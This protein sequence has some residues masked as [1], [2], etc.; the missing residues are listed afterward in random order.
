ME[1][2][3]VE[4]EGYP[5]YA[6]SNL[7]RVVNLTRDALLNPRP[8]GAGYLRVTLSNDEVSKDYYIHRLVAQ[9]FNS[10][11]NPRHQVIHW[12]E[13]LLDNRSDNLRMKR[14]P[15]R[16]LPEASRKI[17]GRRVVVVE[18]GTVFRTAR[19]CA[20][21]IGGDY[22]SVYAVLRGERQSHMGHTFKYYEE[23]QEAA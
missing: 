3:W 9:A 21:G 12:N 7:G 22:S 20:N 17:I 19:E 2:I 13:D 15:A 1:E 11:Y 4:V 10:G 8:N 23:D 18:T 16:R 14:R 5:T 6:V